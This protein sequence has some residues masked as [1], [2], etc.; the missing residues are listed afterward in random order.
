[1]EAVHVLW[2]L[3]LHMRG[4]GLWLE[5]TPFFSPQKSIGYRLRN[6]TCL[7]QVSHM[8]LVTSPSVLAVPKSLF[9]RRMQDA[10]LMTNN[11]CLHETLHMREHAAKMNLGRW[12][13]REAGVYVG[14]SILGT[15]Q[16]SA[17]LL[18][19]GLHGRR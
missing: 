5:C 14:H 6:C 10:G 7:L 1:M 13:R 16:M 4:F 17:Q 11:D 12:C 2:Y 9:C 3:D 18:R 19:I 15:G 8:L